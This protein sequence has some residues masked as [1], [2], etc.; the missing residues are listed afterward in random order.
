[1]KQYLISVI[2]P[3][4]NVDNCLSKCLKSIINQTYKNI[5]IIIIDNT[6]SKSAKEIYKNFTST[7]KRI[8][9]I[10]TKSQNTNNLALSH[11]TG[12]FVHFI[13]SYDHISPSYYEKML[14]CAKEN[15]SDIAISGFKTARTKLCYNKNQLCQTIQ[16]KV[17][18]TK[19]NKYDY[20]FRY[21][22]KRKLLN[23]NKIKFNTNS[24]QDMVF[25]MQIIFYANNITT[26]PTVTY[27][28]NLPIKG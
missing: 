18:A 12:D 24:M 10:T 3:I 6:R 17:S 28:S 25:L 26:V 4:T 23:D 21:L 11:A 16:E 2:I 19:I 8:K 14:D 22:I 15:K 20:I 5:E 13:A 7:D 27:F 9:V 1:M